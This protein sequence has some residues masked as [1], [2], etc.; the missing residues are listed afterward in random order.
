M[1]RK[2]REI[3]PVIRVLEEVSQVSEK[4]KDEEVLEF[5]EM[6]RKIS[7]FVEK[8]DEKWKQLFKTFEKTVSFQL[9]QQN[10]QI[11]CPQSN[12]ILSSAFIS[13]LASDW[14]IPVLGFSIGMDFKDAN[15]NL[16][17]K[18]SANFRKGMVFTL[19]LGFQDIELNDS[20]KSNIN[21]KSA[22]SCVHG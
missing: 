18:N 16:S 20:D 3:E 19:V 9:D 6:I 8:I 7:E 11:S 15:L 13:K 4:G 5:K 2:R 17:S 10:Q 22:V 1:E 21:S 14:F 12:A